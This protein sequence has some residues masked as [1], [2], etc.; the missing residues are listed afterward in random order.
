MINFEKLCDALTS[1]SSLLE[2]LTLKH[3]K[4]DKN[5][6]KIL[7]KLLDKCKRIK[8][9]DLS[10]N[11]EMDNGFRFICLRLNRSATNLKI[12]NFTD[13]D[14]TRDQ[15]IQLQN[16]ILNCSGIEEIYLRGNIS[17]ITDLHLFRVSLQQTSSTCEIFDI[18]HRYSSPL[19]ISHEYVNLLPWSSCSFS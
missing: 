2:N 16:L 1:S 10:H 3:C 9:I 6:G 8:K 19:G 7:G 15:F 14:L 17:I 13:C 5:D 12:I 18:D 4:I 11:S